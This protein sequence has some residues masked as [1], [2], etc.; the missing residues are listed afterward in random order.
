MAIAILKDAGLSPQKARLVAN[1]IRG[2]PV[3]KAF[4]FLSFCEKKAAGILIKVLK[5]AIANAEHN[6]NED[7]DT[8]KV[9]EICVDEAA[10]LKRFRARAKGRSSPILKRRCHIRIRVSNMTPERG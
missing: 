1:E 2:L 6:E 9:S 4:D 7:I 8:L 5:S 3:Q 10:V